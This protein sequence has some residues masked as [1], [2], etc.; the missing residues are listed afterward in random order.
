[1][2]QVYSMF[3]KQRTCLKMVNVMAAKKQ[4]WQTLHAGNTIM[5][6]YENMTSI[7]SPVTTEVLKAE[8]VCEK[9]AF[10][11]TREAVL[12]GETVVS[13]DGKFVFVTLCEVKEA[14]VTSE[15]VVPVTIAK[16]VFGINVEPVPMCHSAQTFHR[17][18]TNVESLTSCAFRALTLLVGHQGRASGL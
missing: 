6:C 4:R 2:P 5:A 9:V 3:Q 10:A 17:K 1:M 16:V 8:V 14:E 7:L 13:V 11:T 18:N 15:I 12:A